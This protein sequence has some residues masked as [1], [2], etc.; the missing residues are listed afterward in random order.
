M[1]ISSSF[2]LSFFLSFLLLIARGRFLILIRS[3]KLRLIYYIFLFTHFEF[4]FKKRTLSKKLCNWFSYTMIR[5]RQ[6]H[7]FSIPYKFFPLPKRNEETTP[8]LR[9]FYN[10]TSKQNPILPLLRSRSSVSVFITQ[11]ATRSTYSVFS[12]HGEFHEETRSMAA[13]T[14]EDQQV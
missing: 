5:S 3:Q 11:Q 4:L 6:T 7:F 9:P 2:L 8:P 13:H 1:Y 14:R 12:F 10:R